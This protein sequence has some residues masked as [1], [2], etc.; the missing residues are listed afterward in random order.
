[1]CVDIFI[2]CRLPFFPFLSPCS[3]HIYLDVLSAA[4]CVHGLDRREIKIYIGGHNISTDYVDTR[5][6]ARIF[7]HEYFDAVSFDF[8][9]AILEL[10]KPIQFGPKIQPA[11][12]PQTIFQ[13]YS[14][15][16][17]VIAGWGRLGVYLFCILSMIC[18]LV[19]RTSQS[20]Y[21]LTKQINFPRDVSVQK[22]NLFNKHFN[23]L[24]FFALFRVIRFF[25]FHRY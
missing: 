5:R 9:I 21:N 6:V 3:I 13:D 8:D 1:M 10:S 25:I 23:S 24:F 16:K 22:L 20:S 11:C 14:G 4:H 17:G 15:K 12:L 18:A 19:K 2:Y 7:E